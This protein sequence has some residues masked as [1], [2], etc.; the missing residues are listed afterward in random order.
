VYYPVFLNVKGRKCVVVGGGQVALRKVEALL[1]RGADVHVISDDLSPELGRMFAAGEIEVDE[2]RYQ[3]GDLRGAFVVVAATD[4]RKTNLQVAGEARGASVLVNVVD[5]AEHSD[6]IVPSV[7]SRGDVTV[8]VSTAGRSP[9]L[10]RKI[11]T[12]LEKEFGPEYAELAVLVGEVR[13]EIRRTGNGVSVDDWQNALDLDA[14][15]DLL[16]NGERERA[17]SMLVENLK[18]GRIIRGES[19]G[20]RLSAE[21]AR[22]T[23]EDC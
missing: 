4:D 6:F 21:T 5:D 22:L 23:T 3:S 10:A 14:L 15:I 16:K 13:S 18:N 8:A 20:D 11:R 7:I 1:A 12:R 9:A 19:V 17:K 2:R